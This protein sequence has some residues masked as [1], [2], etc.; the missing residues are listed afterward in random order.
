MAIYTHDLTNAERGNR[1]VA[2]TF[3]VSAG[4]SSFYT[5]KRIEPPRGFYGYATYRAGDNIVQVVELQWQ[6]Q[7]I[8]LW[9]SPDAEIMASLY[10]T[11]A[12]QAQNLIAL[13]TIFAPTCVIGTLAEVT[14]SALTTC[15]CPYSNVTVKTDTGVTGA[16][17]IQTVATDTGT[18]GAVNYT[19]YDLT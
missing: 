1:V 19:I 8:F 17:S 11:A 9:Q 6:Q 13:S 16:I 2:A 18:L 12:V 10:A 3:A 14:P 5:N 7:L 4:I 15:G